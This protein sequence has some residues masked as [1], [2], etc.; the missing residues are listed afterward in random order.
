ML[1]SLGHPITEYRIRVL[2]KYF[3]RMAELKAASDDSNSSSD[4]QT[5]NDQAA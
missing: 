5:G 3:E 2:E 1:V 4:N